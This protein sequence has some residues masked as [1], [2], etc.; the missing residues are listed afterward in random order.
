M[1]RLLPLLVFL[2]LSGCISGSEWERVDVIAFDE[3][4]SEDNGGFLLDVRTT[5]EW[6]QDGYIENATLIPHTQ[7]E[8]REGELPQDKDSLILLYCRSGNRSQDAAQ[9]LVDMGF[10]NLIELESGITG[11]KEAGMPVMYD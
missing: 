8:S 1:N 2:F 9:T 4:I 6:E 7:L 5:S 10:T 3:A 11:W